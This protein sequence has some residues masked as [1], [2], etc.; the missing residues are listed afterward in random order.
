ME[1][2]VNQPGEHLGEPESVN[3]GEDY[4]RA[5]LEGLLF[6]HNRPISPEKIGELLSID[7]DRTRELLMSVKTL[8]DEEPR[9]G[10]QLI[11]NEEGAQ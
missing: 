6:V 5:A 8:L 11:I 9:R 10:L 4:L 7:A 1:H 2:E 3:V